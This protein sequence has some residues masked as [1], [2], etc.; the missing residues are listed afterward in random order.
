VYAV[1]ATKGDRIQLTLAPRTGAID[2]YLWGPGARTVRTDPANVRRNLVGF[3]GGS[4]RVKRLTR[5]VQRSGVHHVNVYA[6]RGRGDYTLAIS[7]R[8]P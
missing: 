1:R 5:T 2:L 4:R 7:L 8:R 3:Q 6:R